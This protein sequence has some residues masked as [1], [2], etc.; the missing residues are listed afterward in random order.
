MQ[1]DKTTELFTST[2]QN[3]PT[4]SLT[5]KEQP[6]QSVIHNQSYT[7]E[8]ALN[9]ALGEEQFGHGEKYPGSPDY[10][11]DNA[12]FLWE[13]GCRVNETWNC[14]LAC[15]NSRIG[16]NMVWKS[17]DAMFTL[18]NC[19]VYPIILNATRQG[20]LFEDPPGL[21]DKFNII[22][23]SASNDT[24]LSIGHESNTN[25]LPVVN[26]CLWALCDLLSDNKRAYHACAPYGHK[27]YRAYS[28]SFEIGPPQQ[29]YFPHI[30]STYD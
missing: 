3:K 26:G 8:D 23:D 5:L 19:L 4:V 7:Y 14:T 12:V 1:S 2:V 17:S 16:R 29:T 18:H 28:T 9:D 11:N 30:V 13:S 22:H 15:T 21:L 24:E 10:I 20:L 6:T 25:P 27:K